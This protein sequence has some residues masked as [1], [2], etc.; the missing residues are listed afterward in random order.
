MLLW[1]N[2]K[3][4]HSKAPQLQFDQFAKA[5]EFTS[6]RFTSTF[7]TTRLLAKVARLLKNVARIK[8]IRKVICKIDRKLAKDAEI[9]L[10]FQEFFRLGSDYFFNSNSEFLFFSYHSE[11]TLVNSRMQS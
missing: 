6:I 2:T 5:L 9:S 11:N 4:T 1:T 7:F 3:K 8:A 10:G